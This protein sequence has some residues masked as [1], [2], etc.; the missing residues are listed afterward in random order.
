MTWLLG[1]IPMHPLFV[2]AAVVLIPIVALLAIAAAWNTRTRDWL[3][4]AFPIIAS[5]T[6]VAAAFTSAPGEALATQVEQT[7]AVTAHTSIA[8]LAVAAGFLLFLISWV[9]WVW[10]HNYTT[11]RPG[12]TQARVTNPQ[13]IRRWT[14]VISIVQ[15]VIAVFALVA[16]VIVG[17]TG[18]RAVWQ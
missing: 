13:T 17:D 3:G 18:A 1:G 11:V 4:I 10:I 12:H 16:I 6:L 2:H 5:L 14:T 15:T 9:Q 7:A 8:D